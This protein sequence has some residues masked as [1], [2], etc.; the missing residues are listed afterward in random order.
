MRQIGANFGGEQSGHVICLD[1]ATTG[2]GIVSALQFASCM[3]T[4]N[5]RAS[6]LASIY[7]PYPQI[8]RNIKVREKRPL[9][10]IDGLDALS[11]RLAADGLRTLFR[12]SGTENVL[13]LLIEGKDA[14]MVSDRMDEVEAFF[15]EALNA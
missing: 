8:L 12:Y 1:H 5:R 6:E 11:E 4:E 9:S 3:I 14:A 13:R 2:D 10:E 15:A 7:H